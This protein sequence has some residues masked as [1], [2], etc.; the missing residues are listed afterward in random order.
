[1]ITRPKKSILT[2]LL[3]FILF[4]AVGIAAFAVLM[5]TLVAEDNS[6]V[7]NAE[8]RL[9]DLSKAMQE[10]CQDNDGLFPSGSYSY[11]TPSF[12]SLTGMGWA[13]QLYP[14]VRSTDTFGSAMGTSNENQ[15]VG[16]VV[17]YAIN[18]NA[19]RNQHLSA[20]N[21]RSKTILLYQVIDARARIDEPNEGDC[22]AN[23][24]C[25]PAG[26][27]TIIMLVDGLCPRE[28]KPAT[29]DVGGRIVNR[30]EPPWVAPE[31]DGCSLYLLADGHV[32][33]LKPNSVSSGFDADSPVSQQ[34]GGES[35]H[36]AGT[37]NSA[38]LATFST[39]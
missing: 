7:R 4:A 32:R 34:D 31:I 24:A 1:M 10:Y 26:N 13:G 17:A 28:V 21:D 30:P 14:Y 18:M 6:R 15:S 23:G 5:P 36:A 35:G 37:A 39:K 20:W 25:S 38:Y 22:S 9:S 11:D 12:R 2:S 16:S 29:G 33:C 8:S 19:A 27:G 3:Q